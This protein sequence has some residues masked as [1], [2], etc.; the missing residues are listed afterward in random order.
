M[1]IIVIDG[2]DYEFST[3][4]IERRI[5]TVLSP[6]APKEGVWQRGQ[7]LCYR[8]L[9]LDLSAHAA[10]RNS[11]YLKLTRLEY[12]LLEYLVRHHGRYVT[13]DEL[14]NNVWNWRTR[15]RSNAIASR[16]YSLRHKLTKA[17]EADLIRNRRGCGYLLL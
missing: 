9:V 7:Q 4:E 6:T 11:R 12:D 1:K 8:D 17:G 15:V 10:F 3:A 2:I 16:L 14:S 5:R 13:P